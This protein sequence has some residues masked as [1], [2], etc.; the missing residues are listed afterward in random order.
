MHV[1][2]CVSKIDKKIYLEG[3]ISPIKKLQAQTLGG[4]Y[5]I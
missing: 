1:T 5:A 2:N 3:L 4:D